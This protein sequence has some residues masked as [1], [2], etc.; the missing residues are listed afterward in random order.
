[1]SDFPSIHDWYLVDRLP[2]AF[3]GSPLLNSSI[4]EWH[5]ALD[6]SVRRLHSQMTLANKDFVMKNI[7]IASRILTYI[8]HGYVKFWNCDQRVLLSVIADNNQICSY[9]VD[10]NTFINNI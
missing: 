8:G 2:Y 7:W 5:F 6:E 10:N 1:M 3:E 9:F 4:Y